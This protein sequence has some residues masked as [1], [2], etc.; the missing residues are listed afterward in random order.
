MSE[1]QKTILWRGLSV[2]VVETREPAVEPWDGEE[3]LPDGSEG[4]DLSVEVSVNV[5]GHV[6]S[7][8]AS[9]CGSWI[10]PDREGYEYID[11]Q[12]KDL[13]EE[14]LLGLAGEIDR[15]AG[16]ED[17]KRAQAKQMIARVISGL[18]R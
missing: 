4:Y 18:P 8:S 3:P 15:V 6:F 11:S 10:L 17:V 14:S 13:T 1:E 12:V 5:E 9:V 2:A 7:A 16:G